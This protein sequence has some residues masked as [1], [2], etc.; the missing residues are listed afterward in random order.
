M[1]AL[2]KLCYVCVYDFYNVMYS[3]D[4]QLLTW[5][6]NRK[7]PTRKEEFNYK[8]EEE[9]RT[10]SNLGDYVEQTNKQTNTQTD[11]QSTLL[12]RYQS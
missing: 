5:L 3:S 1:M 2:V 6:L 11:R 10:I 12:C 7:A 4:P 8:E 9:D